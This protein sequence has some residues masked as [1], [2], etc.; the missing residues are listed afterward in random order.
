MTLAWAAHMGF[1]DL[2]SPTDACFLV[3]ESP[4]RRKIAIDAV[5][6]AGSTC[7]LG[8]FFSFRF[9]AKAWLLFGESTRTCR[10]LNGEGRILIH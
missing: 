5:A 9:Y 4:S 8:R 7:I 1:L 10:N 3:S 2:S 6:H